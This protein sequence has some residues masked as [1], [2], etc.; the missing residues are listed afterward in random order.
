MGYGLRKRHRIVATHLCS[1]RLLDVGCGGGEFLYW[2]RQHGGWQACGLERV[3][4]M[5]WAAHRCYDLPVVVGDLV[6]LGFA[7]VSFDVVTL[8]TVLEHLQDPAQGLSECARILRRGG[9]LVVRTVT[10]ESWG[11]RFFGPCWLGYDAP[12]ILFVFSRRTLRQ[13]LHKTGFEVLR[14]G[15]YFHDFHPFIWSW[16]NLC[17]ETTRSPSLCQ[18]IDRIACSLP[19]RLLSFPFFALQTLLERNSFFTAVARKL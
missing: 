16:R 8:W 15:C 17:E 3:P 6:Q 1:G 12:R 19:V 9:L 5:A 13:M 14:M 10:M 2:M 18:F 7:P 4:E 11:A